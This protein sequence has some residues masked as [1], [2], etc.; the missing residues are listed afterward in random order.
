MCGILGNLNRSKY[1]EDTDINNFF[2]FGECLKG[3]GPDN[4]GC[5]HV[6]PKACGTGLKRT[7]CDCI[8]G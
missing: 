6:S 1:I 2:R 4:R 3:R 8:S 5:L 7:F